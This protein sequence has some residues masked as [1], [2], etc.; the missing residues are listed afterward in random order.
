MTGCEEEA[1]LVGRVGV[2][3]RKKAVRGGA[4]CVCYCACK[5]LFELVE[6]SYVAMSLSWAAPSLNSHPGKG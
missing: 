3:L 5:C 4:L 2:T 6:S 1:A